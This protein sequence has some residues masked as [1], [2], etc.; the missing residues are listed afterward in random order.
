MKVITLKQWCKERRKKLRD[1]NF[2]RPMRKSIDN[3][4]LVQLRIQNAIIRYGANKPT[5]EETEKYKSIL[6]KN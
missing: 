3:I 4:N 2:W 6:T 5:E 1:D